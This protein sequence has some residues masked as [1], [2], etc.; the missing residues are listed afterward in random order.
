MS[1][2]IIAYFYPSYLNL[3]GDTGNVEILRE[4]ARRRGIDVEV[5]YIDPTVSLSSEAVKYFS[6]VF[7]GGGPDSGQKLMYEDLYKNKGPYLREYV[8]KGGISLFIC[9]SYQLM[10][11]YY[12]SADGTILNGLGI[13]DLYTEHFGNHKPRCIGNV[14]CE[15]SEE[16]RHDPVFNSVN[17]V[18]RT[19]VGFENH[20][21]RTYLGNSLLPLGKI[22]T[23]YG[24][25]A[26]DA[27]EGVLYKNSIGSYLHGPLLAKNPHLADY[28]IAKGLGMDSL[29]ELDDTLIISAHTAAGNLKQ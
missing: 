23:G 8:E 18:G 27:S 28:L 4:R 10:G 9:G 20:G 5:V 24:N 6:I 11:H 29:P 3:Y 15:I 13:F 14:T 1:K 17:K 2:L 21:G 7:M 26:E 16:F 19:L 25:N 12:K 22:I